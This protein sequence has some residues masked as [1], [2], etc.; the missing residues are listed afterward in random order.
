MDDFDAFLSHKF[1]SGPSVQPDPVASSPH[2]SSSSNAMSTFVTNVKLDVKQYPIFNGENTQWPKFKQGVLALAS[3]HGL[4]DVF[5]SKYVV[6][7]PTEPTWQLFHEKNK[8]VYSIWVSRIN[9]GLAL[10]VLREYEDKKDGRGAYFKFMEI[11]EGKHNLEQVA[12]LALAKLN[13]MFLGYNAPGGVPAFI[14]KFRGALQDL[15]DAKEPVSDAMAKSMLLSKNKDR[16]YSHIV[17][18]LIASDDDFEKCVTRLLDKYNM[19]NSGKPA[20]CQNN[21]ARRPNLK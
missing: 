10:S 20:S 2:L 9:S 13:S 15:K 19:M 7:D 14:A 5:D 11:Y 1:T 17:D 4:D 6:P 18:I 21:K 16:D 3:T 8:F 12:L